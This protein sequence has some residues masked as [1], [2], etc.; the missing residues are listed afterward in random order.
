MTLRPKSL[1]ARDIRVSVVIVAS[2]I[3]S[4]VATVRGRDGITGRCIRR[5]H[6]NKTAQQTNNDPGPLL[7]YMKVK[8][9]VDASS[10]PSEGKHDHGAY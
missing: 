1:R 9:K 6:E 8:I 5:V 2:L 7:Y 10:A 3:F 4:Y